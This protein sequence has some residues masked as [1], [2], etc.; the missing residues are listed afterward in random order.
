MHILWVGIDMAGASFDASIWNSLQ[1]QS[2]Y[3]GKE[4]NELSG[5]TWLQ[6]KIEQRQQRG[7]SVRIVLE[8]TGGY[9]K[10]LIAFAYAQAWEVCLPNPKLVRDFT[11]GEGKRNKTDRDDA[12]GL[13]AYGAKKNPLP[14]RELAAEIAELDDLQ[15]RKIQLEKQL[16]A[17]RTRLK[18]WQQRPHP[19]AT[20][21]ESTL[22]TVE[23]LE[24]EIARIEAAIKALLTQHSN[25]N[26][27]I[28]RLKTIPG[29]GNKISLPLLLIL[30]RYK[31]RAKGGGTA[32]GLVAYCGLDPKR[33]DSGTSIR[34][35]PTISKMGDR[36]M[37]HYLFMGAL[38]G[39]RGKNAL[40]HFYCRLV[41]RGKAKKLALVAAARKILVWAFAIFTT[42]TDFDPSKHPIPQIAS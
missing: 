24:K 33:F 36:R 23:Y 19:S 16:Q 27:M 13:A 42:E 5:F 9:E 12:N 25:H 29:V 26:A 38:G 41:E 39:V 15:T 30:H 2:D 35:R 1:A 32:K 4:T 6:E 31:V 21:V 11:R 14:Q 3:L 37:R 40:R 10:K 8:A 28:R 7:Q 34:H 20:A 22:N 18:Q 17:E